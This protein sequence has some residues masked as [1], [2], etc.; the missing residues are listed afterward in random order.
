MARQR[1]SK[2]LETIKKQQEALSRKFREIKTKARNELKEEEKRVNELVGAVVR[3]QFAANPSSAFALSLREF[4][5]KSL[6]GA[7]ER[8]A[9]KLSPLPQQPKKPRTPKSA[10]PKPAPQEAHKSNL[11]PQPAPAPPPAH[12]RFG[13]SFLDRDKKS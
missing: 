4:L 12:T 5:D 1:P 2:Q 11:N 10:T 7:A 3:K 13:M 6:T 9:L 8:V